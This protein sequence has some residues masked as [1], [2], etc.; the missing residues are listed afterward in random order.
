MISFLFCRLEKN[1]RRCSKCLPST[2]LYSL[3]RRAIVCRI[4][5]NMLGL[6]LIWSNA[7]NIRSISSFLVLTGLMYT[8]LS[9]CLQRKKSLHIRLV[10]MNECVPGVYRLSCSCCLGSDHGIEPITHP[11]R[12]SMSYGQKTMYVIQSV[13]RSP[14]RSWPCKAREACELLKGTYK[15]E[16][17]LR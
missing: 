15:G 8:T 1:C 9:T 3:H 11:G 13:I 6:C 12:L 10:G 2:W 4:L 17:K 14:D 5:A 16:V 7:V